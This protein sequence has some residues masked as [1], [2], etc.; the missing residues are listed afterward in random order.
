MLEK[1][2]GIRDITAAEKGYGIGH[3]RLEPGLLKQREKEGQE[4]D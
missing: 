4:F 1:A 2:A 3:F